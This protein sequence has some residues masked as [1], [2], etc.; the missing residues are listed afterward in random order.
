MKDCKQ[1]Q[2]WEMG[3]RWIFQNQICTLGKII[4]TSG[5]KSGS[6]ETSSELNDGSLD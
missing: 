3:K 2:R 4:L 5:C 1:E 6:K